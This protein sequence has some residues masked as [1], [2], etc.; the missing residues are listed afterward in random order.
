MAFLN[1]YLPSIKKEK[2]G[3]AE[4]LEILRTSGYETRRH[5][6]KSRH[7]G[8]KSFVTDINLR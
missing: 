4:I 8:K 6:R 1:Q 2:K 3:G 5:N 7:P